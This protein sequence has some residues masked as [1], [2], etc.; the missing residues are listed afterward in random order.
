MAA[1]RSDCQACS[2]YHR[3]LGPG[4]VD[5][6]GLRYKQI[7][8]CFEAPT[9]KE[10]QM[11]DEMEPGFIQGA[12]GMIPNALVLDSAYTYGIRYLLWTPE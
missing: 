5:V 6:E 7:R 8:G 11:Q 10:T 2:L 1:K 9:N 12:I 4:N 3:G